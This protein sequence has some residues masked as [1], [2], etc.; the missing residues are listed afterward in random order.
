MGSGQPPA[1]GD[2]AVG[3][4]DSSEPRDGGSDPPL[5]LGPPRAADPA[6]TTYASE[7]TA[8]MSNAISRITMALRVR[9]E[10]IDK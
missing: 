10:A 8:L 5:L 9:T 2:D 1:A 7:C 6:A 3:P 4:S